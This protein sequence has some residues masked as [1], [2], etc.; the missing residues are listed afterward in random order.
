MPE[1]DKL[2]FRRGDAVPDG[3]CKRCGM[4]SSETHQSALASTRCATWWP[5]SNF[6][7]PQSAKESPNCA[8]Q[9]APMK[10]GKWTAEKIATCRAQLHVSKRARYDTLVAAMKKR[11]SAIKTIALYAR[12]ST[13]D[14]RQDTETQLIQLRDYAEKAGCSIVA[15]YVDHESGGT[16]KRKH[17]QQMFADARQRKFDLLL[18]WSLD[19][20]SREGAA[21]TLNHLQRLTEAGVEWRSHTE[22]YLDSCGIFGEAVLAILATIAKQERLR[23]SERASAAIARLRRAGTTDHLGR[24]RKIIGAKLQQVRELHKQGKSLREIG[25]KVGASAMTVQRIVRAK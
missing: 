14:G 6:D 2:A 17:F 20:F 11:I 23:R 9:K 7:F 16:S 1:V 21:E 13:K 10:I 8:Y 22:P 12:V 19:R 3:L 24:K 25:E 4:M 18:F 5:F 15:E